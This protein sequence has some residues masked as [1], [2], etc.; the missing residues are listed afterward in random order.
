M[1]IDIP[2]YTCDLCGGDHP[3]D[4]HPQ[5][6]VT[7]ESWQKRY[8]HP[9]KPAYP[10]GTEPQP[11]FLEMM[12]RYRRMIP[13][14]G[15]VLDNGCGN[16]R[17]LLEIAKRGY[18]TYG[19]E[20]VPEAIDQVRERLEKKGLEA[21]ISEGSFLDLPYDDENFDAVVAWSSFQHNSW[22]TAQKAFT[23]TAR[24]LKK[25]GIFMLRVRSTGRFLEHERKDIGDE[26]GLG[27]FTYIPK[28][29]S[30]EGVILHHYSET[31]LHELAVNNN[32]DILEKSETTRYK[33]KPRQRGQW[34]A[35]FR[36]K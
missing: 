36:K 26:S 7:R 1:T 32:L 29:G 4:A 15:K 19:L 10:E 23:E 24:V 13:R 6:N 33:G 11:A 31:E 35:V 17:N 25:G 27:G 12:N 2:K 14:D 8:T 34:V 22:E 30:K 9:E 5:E 28:E 20:L 21:Q 18:E 16:G 3:T